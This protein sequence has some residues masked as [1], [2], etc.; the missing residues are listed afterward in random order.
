MTEYINKEFY[1]EIPPLE[2]HY[3]NLSAAVV[4]AV[5]DRLTAEGIMFSATLSNYKNVVTV[6][7]SDSER[8]AAIVSELMPRRNS[9]IRIIGNADY[10]S[11][12]DKRYINMDADTALKV[13]AVLSGD[14]S[15]RFSGR[16]IGD[17]AT[18]TVS[19]DKNAVNV[20]RIADNIK[21][22]DLLAELDNAGFERVNL[23]NGFVNF[24]NTFTGA[25]EGFDS[26]DM[27]REMFED[28]DNEFFHP[29]TYRIEQTS[30]TLEDAYYIS[31]YD[32]STGKEKTPYYDSNS[33]YPFM[34]TFKTIQAALDY[35][36]SKGI[37]LTNSNDELNM[38]ESSEAVRDSEMMAEEN[39]NR[40]I[41]FP[42]QDGCYADHFSYNEI[43][44]S[45]VWTYFNSDGN[46]GEGEF[47]EKYISEQD[48]YAAY[49][50]RISASDEAAG[51]NAFIN[52]IFENCREAI[53]DTYSGYFQGYAQ[54][55]INKPDSVAEYFGIGENSAFIEDMN[56]L[57][58]LLEESCPD[59]AAE[60][61]RQ[62]EKHD[63]PLDI[64]SDGIEIEGFVGTWYVIDVRRIRN[65][66]L[67]LLESELYGDDAAAL[68]VDENRNI[69]MDNVH[70]GFDDYLDANEVPDD[71]MIISG[72]VASEMWYYGFD[73]YINGE[74]ADS[75]KDVSDKN[76]TFAKL[77]DKNNIVS[78]AASDVSLYH[79]ADTIAAAVFDISEKYFNAEINVSTP[80][81]L[82][83]EKYHEDNDWDNWRT[84]ENEY[85]NAMW[86]L[87]ERN[88]DS[89]EN[90]FINVINESKNKDSM[91]EDRETAL[92]A[93]QTVEVFKVGMDEYRP[94]PKVQET[95]EQ[96]RLHFEPAEDKSYAEQLYTRVNDEYSYFIGQMKKESPEVL[97][98]SAAEI[99]DKDRIR[100]YLEEYS[101][102][103][104]DEQ[105]EALLSRENPLDEI[106]EQ[107]VKNGELHSIEDVDIALEQTADRIMVSLEHESTPP[108]IVPEAV[109]EKLNEYMGNVFLD[110]KEGSWHVESYA[111]IDGKKLFSLESDSY[112]YTDEVGHIIT[113]EDRNIIAENVHSGFAAVDVNNKDQFVFSVTQ[114]DETAYYRN[115]EMTVERLKRE[116][117]FADSPFLFGK[118]HGE[119]I[120]EAEFAEI[121]QSAKGLAVEVNVDNQEMTVYGGNDTMIRM[122]FDD[123]LSYIP[124]NIHKE[125]DE[126]AEALNLDSNTITFCVVTIEGEEPFVTGSYI[127]K[128]DITDLEEYQDYIY[129]TGSKNTNV[130]VDYYQI[131]IGDNE[132]YAADSDEKEFISEHLDDVIKYPYTD[133]FESEAYS[134]TTPAELLEEISG[135]A[136]EKNY[137]FWEDV[138]DVISRMKA[139]WEER[140]TREMN[141]SDGFDNSNFLYPNNLMK[142]AHYSEGKVHYN[143]DDAILQIKLAGSE[144]LRPV[145]A[146]V[147]M[148]RRGVDIYDI[149]MLNIRYVSSDGTVGEKDVTPEQ[150]IVYLAHSEER[151]NAFLAAVNAAEERV[152]NANVPIYT[153]SFAEA[154]EQNEV[155]LFRAS[156]K[157]NISCAHMIDA[158]CSKHYNNNRI[159]TQGVLSDL[160]EQYSIERIALIL[161][162]NIANKDWDGRISGEN[163]DW[164]KALL[165]EYSIAELMVPNGE[166][167]L[168]THP[169]LQNL[170]ANTV[171]ESMEKNRELAVSPEEK[172][173]DEAKEYIRKYLSGEF[174]VDE[175][176]AIPEDL[177]HIGLGY[178]ELGDGAD[179]PFQVEADLEDFAIRY[180]IDNELVRTDKYGTLDELIERELS[181]LKFDY[182]TGEGNALLEKYESKQNEQ[183]GVAAYT[184]DRPV[185]NDFR[186]NKAPTLGMIDHILR[187]GSNEPNSLERIVRQFQKQ[188][189]TEENAE[190]LKKEFGEDGRGYFIQDTSEFKVSV[191]FDEGGIYTAVSDT[192]FPTGSRSHIDWEEAAKRIQTMLENGNYCYQDIIDRARDNDIKDIARDLWYLHQDSNGAFFIPDEYFKGAF[193]EGIERLT[194]LLNGSESL[195][196]LVDGLSKFAEMYK[197]NPDILRFHFHKPSEILSRLK[198][199]QAEYNPYGTFDKP[200]AY[201]EFKTRSDF[202]LQ[203]KFFISEDEKDKLLM[204]GTGVMGGKFRVEEFFKQ[205]HSA[206]DRVDFLKKAYGI[207]GS[208][209]TNYNVDYD[210]KGI[211]LSKGSGETEC[212]VSMGWNEVARR[213]D[214]LIAADKYITVKDID[215]RIRDAKSDIENRDINDPYDRFIIERAMAVLDSYGVPYEAPKRDEV[216]I[217][218]ERFTEPHKGKLAVEQYYES[219][220]PTITDLANFIK[221]SIENQ[222]QGFGLANYALTPNGVMFTDLSEYTWEQVAQAAVK[223][224]DSGR[225]ITA[226]ERAEQDNSPKYEI[227]QIPAGERYHD[228]RFTSYD[229]LEKMGQLPDRFNYEKVYSGRLDD[230]EYDDKLE[231]IFIKF[232]ADRPEEFAGHSLSVS[233]VIVIE[234]EGGKSAHF[235]DSIGFKDITDIFLELD[236]KKEQDIE[237]VNISDYSNIRFVNRSEWDDMTLSDEQNPAFEEITVSYSPNDDGS[238]TKYHY[239]KSNSAFVDIFE[240]ESSV[241]G[242]EMLDELA[243]YLEIM[244]LSSKPE[245]YHFELIDRDGNNRTLNGNNFLFVMNEKQPEISENSVA[246][247]ELERSMEDGVIGSMGYPVD[248]MNKAFEAE[249]S[250]TDYGYEQTSKKSGSE[251][252]VGD[253]FLYN[254]RE[255][256][257]TSEKGIYPDDV[258]V[259][260]EDNT[261]GIAYEITS[262]IDRYKL[263]ENGVFLGNPEKE[264]QLE[265]SPVGNNNAD[266]YEPKIGDLIE[267][268]EKLFR[269]AD[270]N[271]DEATLQT[272]DTLLPET[273]MVS[274]TDLITS[275]SLTVIKES[276]KSAPVTEAAAGQPAEDKP[277]AQNFVITD[278]DF[279][280]AGGAKTRYS[281]NVAAIKTLKAIEA[282]NRTATPEEQNILSKYTGWG[283]IPQAFDINND[284][285]HTE[286]AELR[287]LLTPEEYAA[288]RKSTMNAHY[289]SPTVILAI[290]EGLK[291]LGFEGGKILEP[292]VGI[293]N[294]FGAMPEGMRN[295]KLF[296]VELDSLTGRIA[297]QLYPSAD[298]Q[299][300]GFEQTAFADNSFDVAIGNVPFGDYK[301][302]DRKYNENNFL[303]HDY[304]FA[305]ALDK[306]HPGGVVAFVTSKGTLDK[307]NPEVRKYIAQRAELLGAIRLP[308]NAFKANAGTEV[309]SDIIFL[310]KRERPIEINPDDVEWLKKAETPDGF[311]VNNYFVQHPEMVLGKIVEGNKMYGS[312]GKDTSC[313]PIEGADLKQQLSQAMTRIQGQYRAAEKELSPQNVDE[314]PAPA[315]SRKFSFYAVDGNLY[316]REAEDTMK[317]VS[318]SKDVLNC[319]VGLIELRDNVRELLNLQL[320]N[321]DGTLDGDIA[322]SREKLN[323]A[324]DSFV[325]KYGNVSNKKNSK[326][327][328]GDDGYNIVSALEVKDEK[329]K[330]TG[331]ADIFTHNTVKPK[332]IASHVDTAEEALILSVAEK[333]RVDFDYMT[334]LCGMDKE[335]LISEFKGQIFRLPQ[336]EEK[337]VTADEYLTGNI[338]KKLR[339]LENAPDDMDVSDNRKALEAAMPPRVEAK[340]I[341]VK[342]GAHWVDPKYIE[343]FIKDKFNPDYDTRRKMSVQYSAVAGTWKIEEVSASSKRNYYST[344]TYGTQRKHAYAILEAI[345]NNGDIQVKDRVKDEY[346]NDKRDMNGKYILV[347]ND[348]ETKAARRCAGVIKAEFEDWIFRDPERREALVQKYNEVYNS[349]RHR[350]YDGSHLNFSGMSTDIVLKEHQKNAIARGLYGGNCLLAHAVGAGKTFEMI[351][352]AME[353]KRLGLHNKCLFAVP[354]ALT[355]QMGNDFRRLYPNANILVAT[356]KDFEKGNRL[357]LFAKIAAN[358]WDAVIVGHSQFDRMG[359][360]PERERAYLTEE[361]N[362]LRYELEMAAASGDGKKSF[363]VKQIEKSLASYEDKL[364]KLK[365]AQVKDGFIDFEQLGFDKVFVDESHMYKNLATATKMHNVSGL[366]TQGSARAFNLLMK[367]RYLDG[368]TGGRG[369]T[370]ASGTPVETGYLR[371][372][373]P[374]LR[375]L[376]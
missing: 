88:Y 113:D 2:R 206:K 343:D 361:V 129:N 46:N 148:N 196:E 181:S 165:A 278:D 127:D 11:I 295:S 231:G 90:Y 87:L 189:S 119:R 290:Y 73:V 59:V 207:G 57:I 253:K 107:W 172:Q 312:A 241:S 157:E 143:F 118:D 109:V 247:N 264:R 369:L 294:F 131:G 267:Y 245:S 228:I 144:W 194:G 333:A 24:R 375:C 283:A 225:Y 262:N 66:E 70:N 355:E 350:E 234:D 280:V 120:S 308:N 330:V 126:I 163:K 351:A 275:D 307:D 185:R 13:A 210:S 209:R 219:F 180:Y 128:Y 363:T 124:R 374:I 29:D 91:A 268:Q 198:D 259:S 47:I 167:Y 372:G 356:Q 177:K 236:R 79:T 44:N 26:L 285:W 302:N 112:G 14:N 108:E 141:V 239:N 34:P 6:H 39:R 56:A 296:G 103:I 82:N 201:S 188:K 102:T 153:K 77:E 324:Y 75:F 19:G 334:T 95:V 341:S 195:N 360:S 138:D 21:N 60:K 223:A 202:K 105:Y 191:W 276:G 22:A 240:E 263:A 304:F 204:S 38:W 166:Y 23:N 64:H 281:D 106:Y 314:I 340:D 133:C 358:D 32:R 303:I 249:N 301:L 71:Q 229:L 96:N 40:I 145:D 65:R 151:T 227:Y 104:S 81:Y 325:T 99:V 93:M 318:V 92:K 136:E 17:K 367:S 328:Q 169:G 9:D 310:Q 142:V 342:L 362:K 69:V 30:D 252:E 203:Q 27:V 97:I 230:I 84:D 179:Y 28:M 217:L 178:T 200:F 320:N 197:E 55:Y 344:H 235:V 49:M 335:T 208:G 366:G 174:S 271:G 373:M 250:R 155:E 137:L 140:H 370:F 114:E 322:E 5:M 199:L 256:T 149:D 61:Q 98:Q 352:I 309:T 10:R 359:L 329:G 224:L 190:F 31:C 205:N 50:A 270:I 348:E 175:N 192:A 147:E 319:A 265:N 238:Y 332:T 58:T 258:G 72:E 216:D 68:I 156:K 89:V 116:C 193:N 52:Y 365:D 63:K 86:A 80:Y 117:V 371:S 323:K 115:D 139:I 279:G 159:D 161:A 291:N 135:E 7:K 213:I 36:E 237:Q 220:R 42:M 261:G 20:R 130:T 154:R 215:N 349:I 101:P 376:Y 16:I 110:G 269:I 327:M 288:A 244:E 164:A 41:D 184:D 67:F 354:N 171:R 170:F 299:I 146:V 37:T 292:A 336:E 62:A 158:L 233:D 18:I 33:S 242:E 311:S 111:E 35:A 25:V 54:D 48:I 125:T 221:D 305:K 4:N 186:S 289:T 313:I 168:T 300:K 346:G 345:L 347:I 251:I 183:V 315:G 152:K 100:L 3:I 121:S 293:G 254:D 286:Y 134:V 94:L 1:K 260:Y 218:S 297:Q 339:E 306:V 255:Y 162:A 272:A 257:V 222:R 15:S 173:L 45:F 331:K 326:A 187:C 337:F 212:E 51:R 150:Y 338:R 85:A 122:T 321:S 368:L 132:S 282:E 160:M 78:A 316:Y 364:E 246:D 248:E 214:R 226:E 182:F 274:I 123:I 317:K 43:D 211:V 232:N 176:D 266:V 277:K 8:A 12:S 284:K 243:K 287:T 298:I 74:K 76:G 273:T 353:G 83:L 357:Q 53:I